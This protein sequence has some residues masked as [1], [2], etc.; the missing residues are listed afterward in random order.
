MTRDALAVLT[1]L[2]LIL[3]GGYATE[4]MIS[5]SDRRD[6]SYAP[7][8]DVGTK[9]GDEQVSF[10]NV[11]SEAGLAGVKGDNLAWGDYNN[12]G[13]IDLLVRGNVTDGT[14]LFENRGPPDFKFVDVTQSVGI[15]CRGYCIWGDYDNDGNLDF[16]CAAHGDTLWHNEGP[17]NYRF[18]NATA[19]EMY[20]GDGANSEAA[21]WVDYDNDGLLDIFCTCWTKDD[22]SPYNWPNWGMPDHLWHNEGDGTFSDVT[23]S[24]GIYRNNPAYAA[25]SIAVCDYNDDGWQDIY[26][27]NY[28]LCP[29][30]LWQNQGDGTFVNVAGPEGADV[31]GDADHY[32]G[33]GP[34]YGHTPGCAWADFDNDLDMDLWVSNLAHKDDERSGMNRGAF[35]DDS[36]LLESSGA[37]DYRFHD[38]RQEVGIPV[39]PSGT[40]IYDDEG[41]GYWKDEDYFGCAWGD[42]DNDGDLDLWIPQV[43][44]YSFWDWCYLWRN[45]GDRTFTDQAE[46]LGI[47]VWSNTG[48]AWGDYDNDGDLDL[49]TEGTH[50]FKGIRE[51]HLFRNDGNE[52][53]WLQLELEGTSSNRMAVGARIILRN[54]GTSMSRI[55]GGDNGGHGFQ[56]SPVVHFGLGEADLAD[57][58]EI[59]WPDRTVTELFHIPVDSR[60]HITQGAEFSIESIRCSPRLPFEDEPIRVTIIPVDPFSGG[61]YR[62]EWDLD[63]DGVFEHETV[64]TNEWEAVSPGFSFGK[65]GMYNLSYR[66]YD[67][68]SHQGLCGSA[69]ITVRNRP[70]VA[71]AGEDLLAAEDS[72]VIFNGSGSFDTPSDMERGLQ[73]RWDFGD[74][75]ATLWSG[76]RE[77]GHVYPLKGNYSVRLEVVDDDGNLSSDEL[78]IT[79]YNVEPSAS[80]PGDLEGY[81]DRPVSFS[82]SGCD[83]LNDTAALMFSWDFGDG[84]HTSWGPRTDAEHVYERSGNYTAFL[85]VLDGDGATGRANVTVRIRNVSPTL[86]FEAS[87]H[88][89]EE[90]MPVSFY[91][92]GDDTDSDRLNLEYCLDT[93]NGTKGNWSP[94][95]R[96]THS[97]NVSG[98]FTVRGWV[99]DDDGDTGFVDL[100]VEVFNV[101]P[102][103]DFRLVKNGKELMESQQFVLDA[104][105]SMD[106][107]SDLPLLNYT[108]KLPG[109]M[110]LHGMTV[111]AMLTDV[112]SNRVTLTVRD[113]DLAFS[114][115]NKNIVVENELPVPHYSYE[116][117]TP[118]AGDPVIFNASSTFLAPSD[119]GAEFIWNFGDGEM[120]TGEETTH[121]YAKAGRYRLTLT[122]TDDEESEVSDSSWVTVIGSGNEDGADGLIGSGGPVF[123]ILFISGAISIIVVI[124]V[125][126]AALVSWRKKRGKGHSG[127]EAR[128]KPSVDHEHTYAVE[129]CGERPE[130]SSEPA[131]EKNELKPFPISG[132]GLHIM[133]LPALGSLPIM[134]EYGEKPFIEGSAVTGGAPITGAYL[135][136]P[137]GP[138]KMGTGDR[139]TTAM[140]TGDR[141]STAMGM[142]DGDATEIGTGDGDA[143]E[144]GTGDGDTTEVGHAG[145]DLVV[146]RSADRDTVAMGLTD[147]DLESGP[148]SNR[149]P[150]GTD[151]IRREPAKR[152]SGSSGTGPTRVVKRIRKVR[153]GRTGGGG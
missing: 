16:F 59:R 50:P 108:W 127:D 17:P 51:I 32:Q 3:F 55:I 106:T 136:L 28:H 41:Q 12:D 149:G 80:V 124:C 104:S 2:S 120:G 111:N 150:T 81:E 152:R 131:T 126:I 135:M 45:N 48:A 46:T 134:D 110:V 54:N 116:P 74:G 44:T 67:S 89:V 140:G 42:Y 22:Y 15:D 99:R 138:V 145:G 128:V 139:D 39:T 5:K 29:N 40:I 153:T 25:M 94:A 97:Y 118:M 133:P 85:L 47:R 100:D 75:A 141:D 71:A 27:G 73:Y 4:F 130:G 34:Y 52:N 92:N 21:A 58:I 62:V 105:S 13:Y 142:G 49:V 129:G 33:A 26:V 35:C 112:G 60:L 78:T 77:T 103:A 109:G 14:M 43:K 65:K 86:S 38:I 6:T 63:D 70:P 31:D 57:H 115:V 132:S 125:G 64:P 53:H 19:D 137:P 143:T 72:L 11:S 82:G 18:T 84:N 36:Q 68:S 146:T 147:G 69:S 87:S 98:K 107:P 148:S 113:D 88:L 121:V 24:A 114:T 30:Y 102:E 7:V 1:V 76:D 61:N 101:K 117:D 91:F 66:L 95:I 151:P 10:L 56:N 144:I 79:I 20:S 119:E 83:T 9:R 93:G 8:F 122:V 90:D 96:M 23:H 123:N 37:G